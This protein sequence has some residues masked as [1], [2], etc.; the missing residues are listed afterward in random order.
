MMS[1]NYGTT[2]KC[3]TC[4]KVVHVAEMVSA[5]GVPYH[6][7]CFK[8]DT[9]NGRLAISNYS[10]VDGKLYC[11]PHFEQLFRETGSLTTR[12]FNS[13]LSGKYAELVTVEGEFFHKQCFRCAHGGCNLTMS[14][15]AALDGI[16]Y[17][18]PH[19]AQLFKEKGS[20]SHLTKTTSLKKNAPPADLDLP[21]NEPDS[22]EEPAPDQE[23][24]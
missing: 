12:K 7:N 8:C 11:K 1:S 15:Y 4:E 16:V 20:Y 13:S 9:C 14:S 5:D 17:C 24:T 6:K 19:F 2:Q 10:T 21:E 3:H 23:E 22:T 18:K